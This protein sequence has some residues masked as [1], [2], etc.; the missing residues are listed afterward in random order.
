[1]YKRKLG[2]P[3]FKA[4]IYNKMNQKYPGERTVYEFRDGRY[5]INYNGYPYYVTKFRDDKG[6]SNKCRRYYLVGR[7]PAEF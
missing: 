4:R 3:L 6:S 1:M 7:A 5:K 2:K